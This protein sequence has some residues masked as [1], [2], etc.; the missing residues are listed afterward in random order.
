M[1]NWI[2]RAD[3]HEASVEELLA[4]HFIQRQP[5]SWPVRQHRDYVR[6]G[7]SAYIWYADPLGDGSIVAKATVVTPVRIKTP[8]LM[9]TSMFMDV[10]PGPR[11]DLHIEDLRLT[12]GGGRVPKALLLA[13]PTLRLL[14]ILRWDMWYDW[15]LSDIEARDLDAVWIE[16]KPGRF[17]ML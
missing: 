17:K 4:G 6:E 5:L 3:P 7:D 11:V 10:L 9:E 8:H 12:P 2:F 16:A 14:P 1:N 13:H 15:P